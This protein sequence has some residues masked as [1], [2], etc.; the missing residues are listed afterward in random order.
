MFLFCDI[1]NIFLSFW[2]GKGPHLS[3]PRPVWCHHLH[4]SLPFLL[5]GYHLK[6]AETTNPPLLKMFTSASAPKSEGW[7]SLLII[8]PPHSVSPRPSQPCSHLPSPEAPESLKSL[9]Y[10][11]TFQ[12]VDYF[13]SFFFFSPAHSC[14]SAESLYKY[15]CF[16]SGFYLTRP[17][18]VCLPGGFSKVCM[19]S[20]CFLNLK[21][22]NDILFFLEYYSHG[23][24][25][26]TLGGNFQSHFIGL[27]HTIL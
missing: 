14:I 13:S 1:T 5:F 17:L 12:T 7:E 6:V 26:P 2:E 15:P 10:L 3:S 19:W 25:W 18:I 22:F 21:S 20:G 27:F 4:S 11:S 24:S 23:Y 16:Q 9:M 8:S